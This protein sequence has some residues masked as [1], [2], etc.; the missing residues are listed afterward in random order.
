[1]M[2]TLPALIA[3][4]VIAAGLISSP[5]AAQPADLD[6]AAVAAAVRYSLPAAFEGYMTRCFEALE[7]DGYANTNAAEMRTK[8]GDGAAAAWPG[9][10]QLIVQIAE[11]E[12]G[13]SAAL[14]ASMDDDALRPFVDNLLENM[15]AQEIKLDDCTKIE[16][17]LQILA[18]LPADNMAALVGFFFELGTDIGGD[19]AQPEPE[20]TESR[21]RKLREQE[22]E[23]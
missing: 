20:M 3:P 6:P 16:R 2:R 9:A 21:Q 13:G 11:E 8:F 12:A 22:E 7:P 5:A 18:P 19:S 10:R 17:G 4:F 14:F 15:A 1:M 23:R